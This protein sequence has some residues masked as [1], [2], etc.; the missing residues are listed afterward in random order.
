MEGSETNKFVGNFR[1]PGLTRLRQNLQVF[2]RNQS[3]VK[4]RNNN[5]QQPIVKLLPISAKTR[6][7]GSSLLDQQLWCFGY[8]IRRPEG[9]LL[10]EYGFTRHRPPE[11]KR[12][13]N[14]YI[15]CPQPSCQIG[16]W[17][18]GLFYGDA[19]IGGI[20]LKRYQFQ[21]KLTAS[22]VLSANSIAQAEIPTAHTPRT[23]DEAER[24]GSLAVAALRWLSHYEQWIQVNVGVSYRQYCID[25]W[26]RS[27]QSVVAEAVAATTWHDS[28]A[29]A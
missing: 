23:P 9:N 16:L 24:A 29:L 20:F 12:G 5:Q 4:E 2:M 3:K 10:L 28:T 7:L 11:G 6:K 13:S 25:R 19:Q 18:S 1:H 22:A 14:C 21:P 8:D 27:K 15:F 26:P 17:G